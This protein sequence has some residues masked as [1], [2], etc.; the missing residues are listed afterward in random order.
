MP[1]PRPVWFIWVRVSTQ[2]KAGRPKG[3]IARKRGAMALG[4]CRGSLR[5]RTVL[6]N[7]EVAGGEVIS[8]TW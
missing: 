3:R 7:E 4:T 2:R 1:F 6:Q 5:G 8:K